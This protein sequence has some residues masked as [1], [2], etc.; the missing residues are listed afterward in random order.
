LITKVER[1]RWMTCN[2]FLLEPITH[3]S[4]ECEGQ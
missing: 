3:E 1:V 4:P 2:T